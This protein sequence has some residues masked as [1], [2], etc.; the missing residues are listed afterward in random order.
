MS[1]LNVRLPPRL[2]QGHKGDFGT[3][4]VV[5][6]QCGRASGRMM[7]GGPALTAL[8]ALRSGAGLAVLAMP[9]PILRPGMT[10]APSATGIAL[11]TTADGELIASG[12]SEAI[13]RVVDSHAVLAVGPGLGTSDAVQQ[14]VMR[15]AARVETPMVLD[16]DALNAIAAVRSFGL[17]L[18]APAILTPHPGEW[19]RLAK[20]LGIAGDPVDPRARPAAVRTMAQ[21]LGAIVVLKGA[22]TVVSDGLREW[23]CGVGNA[24]LATGGTG[25]VLTGVIAGLVAQFRRG[26]GS[27]LGLFEC[28]CLGVEIHGRAADAWAAKN[29]SAG[30]LAMDL[31]GEIPPVLARLRA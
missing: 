14:V 20:A 4:V 10:I 30:L 26:E 19:S 18:K 5:G 6:G 15:L 21:R 31:V 29:G 25:D 27:T 22:G 23:T 1:E 7:I 16:A 17:D 12:A 8:A 3:V 2:P 9:E 24:A 28:A 11:P 13:D